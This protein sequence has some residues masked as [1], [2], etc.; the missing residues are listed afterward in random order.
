M[1]FPSAGLSHAK[2]A[3]KRTGRPFPARSKLLNRLSEKSGGLFRKPEAGLPAAYSVSSPAASSPAAAICS[4]SA[5]M[6][7]SSSF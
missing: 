5:L 7:A 3:R 6:S 4:S 1:G 2:R